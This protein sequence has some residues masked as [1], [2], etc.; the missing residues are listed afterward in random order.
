MY[1]QSA[2]M[3]HCAPMS[4]IDTLEYAKREF[5]AIGGCTLT[6]RPDIPLT[7]QTCWTPDFAAVVSAIDDAMDLLVGA[8]R[9]TDR[10]CAGC[11]KCLPTKPISA[12][13]KYVPAHL[14][15]RTPEE[16]RS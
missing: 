15:S 2:A 3:R 5:L 8:D 6:D 16:G 10:E 1:D 4:L 11:S 13:T 7:P 9:R 12:R 14:D